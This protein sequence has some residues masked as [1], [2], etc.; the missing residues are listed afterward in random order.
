LIKK[1]SS[2]RISRNNKHHTQQQSPKTYQANIDKSR[3]RLFLKTVWNFLIDLN[4]NLSND[5]P[6]SLPEKKKEHIYPKHRYTRML[7][8]AHFSFHF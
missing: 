2:S 3:N 5:A 8:V 7:L 6:V 4:M 1:V